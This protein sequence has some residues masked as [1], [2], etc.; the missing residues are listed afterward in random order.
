MNRFLP[1]ID[2]HPDLAGQMQEELRR[3]GCKDCRRGPV[4]RKFAALLARRKT[5]LPQKPARR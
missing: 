5:P 4:I 2:S 3:A 1:G